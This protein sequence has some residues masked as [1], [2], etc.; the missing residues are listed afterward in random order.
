MDSFLLFYDNRPIEVLVTPIPTL[1]DLRYVV[2]L[3]SCGFV[4]QQT[5]TGSLEVQGAIPQTLEDGLLKKVITLISDNY[6]IPLTPSATEFHI[7][8]NVN[9]TL[10]KLRV[11]QTFLP[12]GN[13][14][15]EV[16]AKNKTLVLERATSKD[17]TEWRLIKGTVQDESGLQKII[18]AIESSLHLQTPVE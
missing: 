8:I 7:I 15:F 5:K 14:H 17:I 3:P 12:T 6:N 4:L 16:I 2:Q 9:N 13:M 11:L 1:N 10:I 18:N